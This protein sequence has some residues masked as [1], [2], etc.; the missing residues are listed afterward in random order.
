[1][2]AAAQVISFA[3]AGFSLGPRSHYPV[4]FSLIF[5]CIRPKIAA[6]SSARSFASYDRWDDG[7]H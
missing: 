7:H 4:V 2:S 1:M 6:R 3:S 5:Y